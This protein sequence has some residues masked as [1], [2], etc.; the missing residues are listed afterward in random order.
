SAPAG[1]RS[2]V[3]SCLAKDCIARRRNRANFD[4]RIQQRMYGGVAEFR[5]RGV[6]KLA[7]C[8]KFVAKR[9]FAAHGEPVFRGFAIDQE[10]RASRSS[11]GRLG[12]NAVTF[13]ADNK[14]QRKIARSSVQKQFSS[15]DHRGNNALGVASTAT[16]NVRGVFARGKE[17]R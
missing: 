2:N 9:S 15:G 4:Q 12:P 8:G 11:G 6:R 13:L 16:V 14:E 17:Q 1:K 7:A 5:I 3:E 10:A